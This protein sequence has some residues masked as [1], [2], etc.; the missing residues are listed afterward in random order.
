MFLEVLCMISNGR[1]IWHS[2]Q[3]NRCC[4]PEGTQALLATADTILPATDS[5]LS[6]GCLGAV[7]HICAKLDMHAYQR[8]DETTCT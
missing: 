1:T 7:D 8:E 4:L 3:T 5:R 2:S 6:R